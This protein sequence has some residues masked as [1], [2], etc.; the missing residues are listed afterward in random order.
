MKHPVLTMLW[1]G[2]LL[3]PVIAAPAA[4]QTVGVA[5]ATGR[6]ADTGTGVIGQ[7]QTR[8]QA[9]PNVAP[10]GR[11]DSRIGNRVQNRVR[12]RIDRYYDPSANATS[13]FRIAGDE[14]RAAGTRPR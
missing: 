11:I 5:A 1:L 7:R 12:N 8:E 4:A 2:L 3:G 9:A 10:L 13:P 14:A 6:T